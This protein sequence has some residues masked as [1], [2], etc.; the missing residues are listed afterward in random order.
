MNYTIAN[1]KYSKMTST[2]TKREPEM[3]H[4]NVPPACSQLFQVM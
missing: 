4:K 2:A 3:Y 1:L